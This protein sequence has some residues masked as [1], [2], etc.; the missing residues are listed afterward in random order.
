MVYGM[1]QE[2]LGILIWAFTLQLQGLE[3]GQEVIYVLAGLLMKMQEL[4]PCPLSVVTGQEEPLDLCLK[5]CPGQPHVI[6]HAL[7]KVNLCKMA[8]MRPFQVQVNSCCLLL[9]SGGGMG[10]VDPN[11]D[12]GPPFV[13]LL[14]RPIIGLRGCDNFLWRKGACSSRCDICL[15][16]EELGECCS[17]VLLVLDELLHSCF[18]IHG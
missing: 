18:P 16:C 9:I 17:E 2:I 11:L 14:W 12:F 15:V 6:H 7:V 3:L 4:G 5:D 8:C 1:F 13:E 10:C